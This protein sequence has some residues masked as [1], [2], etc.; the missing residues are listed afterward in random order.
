MG[1]WK[2]PMTAEAERSFSEEA[3]TKLGGAIE[4]ALRIVEADPSELVAIINAGR[5]GMGTGGEQALLAAM[6]A[7][8]TGAEAQ[9]D[10]ADAAIAII[11]GC[12]GLADNA[13]LAALDAGRAH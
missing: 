8:R 1:K 3:W 12:A 5:L 6:T 11:Q 10:L 9:I 13:A 2:R 7:I 4:L